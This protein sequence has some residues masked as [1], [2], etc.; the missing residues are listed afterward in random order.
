M[1]I[2]LYRQPLYL[3]STNA[4]GADRA[5][6]AGRLS[7][8]QHSIRDISAVGE[9]VVSHGKHLWTVSGAEATADAVFIYACVHML[10][11][12]NEKF[13]PLQ[14]NGASVYSVS[15]F[16]IF[17]HIRFASLLKYPLF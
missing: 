3:G 14:R 13:V 4:D 16:L 6:I 17:N 9:S 7:R 15:Q 12:S 1:P 8:V 11:Q 2:S 5:L 10:L